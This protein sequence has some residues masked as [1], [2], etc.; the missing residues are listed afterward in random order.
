M[1][2][3]CVKIEPYTPPASSPEC[4]PAIPFLH[5]VNDGGTYVQD[6]RQVPDALGLYN[7]SH[8]QQSSMPSPVSP[9]ITDGWTIHGEVVLSTSLHQQSHDEP[10]WT[11]ATLN[12][13]STSMIWDSPMVHSHEDIMHDHSYLTYPLRDT[14]HDGSLSSSVTPYYTPEPYASNDSKASVTSP[15]LNPLSHGPYGQEQDYAP[16]TYAEVYGSHYSVLGSPQPELPVFDNIGELRSMATNNP[17]PGSFDRACDLQNVPASEQHQVSHSDPL[18]SIARVRRR[19]PRRAVSSPAAEAHYTCR[20]PECNWV[21][22]RKYNY[23][24]H[25][26]THNPNREKNHLC[27]FKGCSRRFSRNADLER[28]FDSKHR[29]AREFKCIYCPSGFNRKDTLRRHVE[30]GCTARKMQKTKSRVQR[31]SDRST[32]SLRPKP[33][34][35][36]SLTTNQSLTP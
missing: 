3:F 21:F 7:M 32:T 23:T 19:R 2:H 31:P 18:G 17:E 8:T 29:N 6:H 11:T 33:S 16:S 20:E 14:K 4:T 15:F 36:R 26:K 27:S 25:L 9:S 24:Q 35:S 1:D 5:Q 13:I 28:H 30:D 10:R 12:S 22:D 34:T